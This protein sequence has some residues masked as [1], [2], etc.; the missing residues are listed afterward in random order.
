MN[1]PALSDERK[2]K[3]KEKKRKGKQETNQKRKNEPM[4]RHIIYKWLSADLLFHS[5][6]LGGAPSGSVA[7]VSKVCSS[8]DRNLTFPTNIIPLCTWQRLSERALF[9]PYLSIFLAGALPRKPSQYRPRICHPDLT[10][11]RGLTII[12]GSG[13][14][15]RNPWTEAILCG[16]EV[17]KRKTKTI[18]N[19]LIA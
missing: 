8:E 17:R 3:E 11:P 13:S 9:P 12:T 7:M 15:A 5:C 14:G 1:V 10:L 19:F 4:G 18:A 16:H 6:C 2:E